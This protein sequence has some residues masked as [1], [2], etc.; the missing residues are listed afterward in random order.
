MII[1]VSQQ[2]SIKQL[3][4]TGG[5]SEDTAEFLKQGFASNRE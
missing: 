1:S 3:S 5:L 2:D 4:E